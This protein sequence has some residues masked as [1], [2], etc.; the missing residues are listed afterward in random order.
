MIAYKPSING[1]VYNEPKLVVIHAMGEMIDTDGVDYHA[2]EWL[3]KLGLSAHYL[4]TPSG[5]Q[6]KTREETQ[7]AFH[8]KGFNTDS[9]GIEILVPGLHNYATFLQAIKTNYVTDR[10]YASLVSLCR[11]LNKKY[12]LKWKRHSDLSP[13]RKFDPGDG[14]DWGKFLT[15]ISST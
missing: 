5:I 9:I 3:E 13:D 7:G 4:I 12:D 6:I 15:D 8:A 14:F 2:S 10:Q 11:N 1:F